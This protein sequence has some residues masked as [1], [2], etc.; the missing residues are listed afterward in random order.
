[1][2][3]R[4]SLSLGFWARFAAGL[5]IQRPG[6]GPS[7][8]SYE[9]QQSRR[10]GLQQMGAKGS[11]KTGGRK[12]GT[13]NK[14]TDE[15]RAIAERMGIDP[16]E[17]LLLFADGDWKKLGY[18]KPKYVTGV[19]EWGTWYKWT[20]DPAVRAK[21]AAEACRFLK[22]QLKSV[23][24]EVGESMQDAIENLNQKELDQRIESLVK[25]MAK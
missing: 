5:T 21:A 6:P 25:A 7:F 2:R 18:D 15:A 19:N 10:K 23:E 13:R 17:V 4:S 9:R 20:I 22:P 1:M 24:L 11:S 14:L 16:F 12:K 3:S 8:Q